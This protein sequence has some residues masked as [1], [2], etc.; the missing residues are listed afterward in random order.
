MPATEEITE[1]MQVEG[2]ES[3]EGDAKS[4]F[5]QPPCNDSDECSPHNAMSKHVMPL[6]VGIDTG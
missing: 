2:C 5:R 4:I 1:Q 3:H 6:P